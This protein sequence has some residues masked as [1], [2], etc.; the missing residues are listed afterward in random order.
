MNELLIIV[1]A[2]NE[3]LNIQKTLED[4]R[5]NAAYGDI[6]VVDD[7]SKDATGAK[8]REM[9]IPVVSHRVNLGL[10]EAIRTGMKYALKK[11]YRYCLQFDGDGQHD[12]SAVERMLKTAMEGDIDITIGSRYLKEKP[13]SLF[14]AFGIKLISACVFV[15]SGSRITDPTSGMRMYSS[16]VM[17]LFASSGHYTPEPD[18]LAY[19]IRCGSK[20]MEVPVKMT[21]R[22]HGK[23]YLDI[24]ESIRY[25]FR[26]C[27]SILLIQ[28]FR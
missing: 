6:L 26:M 17:S 4:L 2:Y 24:T 23:S 18:T 14:K 25:M 16:K 20:A 27:T 11:N 13:K 12:A 10:S 19:L 15:T 3:E 1:P 8:C 22:R 28:W 9:G 21:E 7:G 5:S